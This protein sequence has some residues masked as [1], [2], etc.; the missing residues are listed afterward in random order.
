[1][2]S[3]ITGPMLDHW[4]RH[5]YLVVPGVFAG[6]R[7]A[8]I[9]SWVDEIQNWPETAGQHMMYFEDNLVRP[10][11]RMLNRVENFAPYHPGIEALLT[12]ELQDACAS[13]FGVKAVLFKEKI[14]FKLPGGGGFEAHQDAQ[15]GWESYAPIFITA[16]V[17]VD[18][19]TLENGCLELADWDHRLALVGDLWAPLTDAQVDG[20]DF[21]P[22]PGDPGDVLFFDSYLPHRSAPNLTSDP[23]RVLYVTYNRASDGDHRVRY[24]ADK[25]ASYPPD[26]ERE[27]GREYAYKV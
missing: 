26:I 12:G 18:P 16:T 21:V 5:G 27:P 8:E 23:R 22:C 25:R 14:N 2:N 7:L 1:M 4:K 17:I 9:R 13:L 10:G 19:A 11:E 6:D 3:F 20:I 24:Y 15:A